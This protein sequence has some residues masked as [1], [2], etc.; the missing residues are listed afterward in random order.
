MG[1]WETAKGAALRYDDVAR[2]LEDGSGRLHT[3]A[4]I[5]LSKELHA[6]QTTKTAVQQIEERRRE[7]DDLLAFI[8]ECRQTIATGATADS[9]AATSS[10]ASVSAA[11]SLLELASAEQDGVLAALLQLEQGL[12][13]YLLPGSVDHSRNAILEVR[14][15]T[16]GEEAALFARDMLLMYERYA[17]LQGWDWELLY[18][19]EGDQGGFKEAAALIKGEG[20][21]GMMRMEAG[22]HRVQRVPATDAYGRIHTSAM[23]VAVLPEVEEVDVPILDRDIRVDVFRSGGAGGQHVNTTDSAVRLTHLPSGLVVSIQDERSQIQNR[24]K[25]MRVLR[26]RLY[27]R[28]RERERQ[29]R[30]LDRKQ[31]VGSGDRSE[32]IRTY[33]YGQNRVTDHRVGITRYGLDRLMDSPDM[34]TEIIAELRHQERLQQIQ[35]MNE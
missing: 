21:Y 13:D 10:A 12:L 3:A 23:T 2:Q 5:A 31:Q 1:S 18:A 25:A 33:N 4:M 30:A 6:L 27:E 35:Q 11:Q 19:A 15:G 14:A 22:V 26:S 24:Q 34:L 8:A 29:R 7:L 16:G 28:E 20:A 9:D 32:R 17:R